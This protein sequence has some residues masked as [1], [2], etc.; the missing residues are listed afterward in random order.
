[1]PADGCA[2]CVHAS[3]LRLARLK[4]GDL[5]TKPRYSARSEKVSREG[6][7]GA[8]SIKESAP[9][10]R[11]C[12]CKGATGI[13]SWIKNQSAT[14]CERIRLDAGESR[15]FHHRCR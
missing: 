12:G 11:G 10:L 13:I 9:R 14:S 15:Q 7:V 1:M 8:A 5:Y 4:L 3:V 6:V 2:I